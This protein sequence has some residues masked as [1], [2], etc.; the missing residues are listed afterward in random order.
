M[1][2][3]RTHHSDDMSPQAAHSND[4]GQQELHPLNEKLGEYASL[5]KQRQHL[6]RK[7]HPVREH[8]RLGKL[9]D[10]MVKD[11]KKWV[12]TNGEIAN[13]GIAQVYTN[14]PR[15]T[16]KWND[17]ALMALAEAHPELGITQFRTETESTPLSVRYYP[18]LEE[19]MEP[20]PE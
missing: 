9:I 17:E 15:T 13:I 14:T 7:Y 20:E 4:Q 2:Q 3:Q 18:H 8:M 19:F 12:N 11:I 1:T 6:E 16:V 10:K 5:S